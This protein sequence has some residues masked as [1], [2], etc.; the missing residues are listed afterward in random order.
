[1]ITLITT[2][3]HVLLALAV[4]TVRRTIYALQGNNSEVPLHSE[5][6][7]IIDY[8][9]GMT[10]PGQKVSKVFMCHHS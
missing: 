8:T 3:V 2:Q 1:V 5:N 9:M 4:I 7:E 6:D 10:M